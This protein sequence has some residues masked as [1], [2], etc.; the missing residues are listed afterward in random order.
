MLLS[1]QQINGS[2]TLATDID[3]LADSHLSWFDTD[4]E[5]QALELHNSYCSFEVRC[6]DLEHVSN[7]QRV[8]KRER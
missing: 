2:A 5:K 6:Y 8:G 3:G 4:P 1:N 7:L